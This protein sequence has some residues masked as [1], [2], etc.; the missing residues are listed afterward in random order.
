MPDDA[1]APRT[2]RLRKP[3]LWAAILILGGWVLFFDS[4]SLVKRTLWYQEYR[5]LSSENEMLQTEIA[6]LENTLAQPLSDEVIEQIAREHYG[7]R[8]PGE[9]VYPVDLKE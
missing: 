7:M 1:P 5:Q 9:T 3:L 4:H 6:R 2:Y 8:K